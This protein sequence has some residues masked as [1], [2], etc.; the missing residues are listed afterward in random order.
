MITE[1]ETIQEYTPA[2]AQPLATNGQP[3][4][5]E[6]LRFEHAVL[7]YGKRVILSDVNFTLFAGDY[8]AVVGSNGSGKTT[9]LRSLLGNVRALGGRISYQQPPHFGYV[10]QLQTLDEFFPL[11]IFEVVMMGRYGRLG[12]V[13]RPGG[14]DREKVMDSLREVGIEHLAHRLYRELSGGQKQRALIARALVGDPDVL[15]LDE[16]TSDLDIAAEK[17]IMAL[18]DRVHAEHHIAVVMVS[19]SLNTVANHARKIGIIDQGKLQ[20]EDV[21]T[22]M[23]TDYLER[24]YGIPLRVLEMN[25]SRVV[26]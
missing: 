22:V 20:L 23:Q 19:H 15:V 25:G 24:L 17:A 16:H 26:V 18:I 5:R 13:R 6:I 11:T 7:G 4:Q 12:V 21:E 3:P 14:T 2:V 9:F 10:P 1:S 8:V